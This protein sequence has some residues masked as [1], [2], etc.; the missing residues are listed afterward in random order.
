MHIFKTSLEK[1]RKV[2]WKA[3]TMS[4]ETKLR[5]NDEFFTSYAL[6][7]LPLDVI[8]RYI[9]YVEFLLKWELLCFVNLLCEK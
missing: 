9:I 6:L 2:F 7:T 3:L 1:F 4:L 8:R 5:N